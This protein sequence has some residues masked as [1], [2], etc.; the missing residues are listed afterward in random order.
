MP[1]TKIEFD[2]CFNNLS[3]RRMV[4]KIEELEKEV[5]EEEQSRL[6]HL[7]LLKA[8]QMSLVMV[9]EEGKL[10]KPEVMTLVEAM[11]E[12]GVELAGFGIAETEVDA[13]EKQDAKADSRA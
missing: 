5:R 6:Q 9:L 8:N 12:V 1:Q 7:K 3:S 10:G 2:E 4:K 11:E 13:T